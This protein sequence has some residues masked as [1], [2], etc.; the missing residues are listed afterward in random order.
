MQ[1][2]PIMIAPTGARLTRQDH[3]NL[4]VTVEQSIECALECRATGA[5]ALHA[6][7]RDSQQKHCLS[8]PMYTEL[9]ALAQKRCGDDFPV[10]ITTEAFGQYEASEQIDLLKQLRPRFAS[11]AV[12]EIIRQPGDEKAAG[13]F[14]Q[15]CSEEHIG[16][17][18]I[19]YSEADLDS[20][21]SLKNRGI[22][23]ENHH[24]VLMVL[25]RYTDAM[26]AD[27][28]G[29][30]AIIESL[31]NSRLHWM[32]CAF[33]ITET[34]CLR[35]AALAG[36]AIRIGF[37]NNQQNTDGSIAKSNAER[38]QNLCEVLEQNSDDKISLTQL[39]RILGAPD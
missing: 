4:P 7:V 23:P 27:V 30:D 36:G 10:Q 11:V 26:V 8:V 20:F 21:I 6:H 18:H 32:M 38:V 24:A 34:E 33:G 22:I 13:Q 12:R 2:T 17:Q 39:H 28:D 9:L 19:L 29:A 15:W 3:P 5:H 16:I 37:E 25:G 35:K 14:Y 1:N 31:N